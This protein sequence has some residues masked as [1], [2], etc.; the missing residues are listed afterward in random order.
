MVFAK[1]GPRSEAEVKPLSLKVDPVE[2]A[3]VDIHGEEGNL[4]ST[5]KPPRS[6]VR[7]RSS[8]TSSCLVFIPTSSTRCHQ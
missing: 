7:I 5:N 4:V 2:V 6:C 8:H 1:V 3:K